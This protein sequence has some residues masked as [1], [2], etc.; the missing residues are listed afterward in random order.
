MAVEIRIRLP[1]FILSNRL[2]LLRLLSNIRAPA[3]GSGFPFEGTYSG[4]ALRSMGAGP[5]SL[6]ERVTSLGGSLMLESGRGGA[7]LDVLLP[8]AGEA[9]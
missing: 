2:T 6:L 1:R 7:R 9:S 3:H 8:I 4:D 5:R